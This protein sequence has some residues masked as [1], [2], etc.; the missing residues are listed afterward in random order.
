MAKLKVK[1]LE[2]SAA[3]E[4]VTDSNIGSKLKVFDSDYT[5]LVTEV[6]KDGKLEG[7]VLYIPG[8]SYKTLL[9]K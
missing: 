5:A 7:T 2:T 4:H 9:D 1:Q 3:I 8:V 6:L